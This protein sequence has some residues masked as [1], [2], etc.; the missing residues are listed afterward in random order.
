[1]GLE[2]VPRETEEQRQS[3]LT[4]LKTARNN[5]P[6]GSNVVESIQGQQSLEISDAVPHGEL[7]DVRNHPTRN[8][9]DATDH[10][11]GDSP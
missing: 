3:A 6:S 2:R 5:Y 9:P 4:K 10:R 1:M 7:L 8:I 11:W